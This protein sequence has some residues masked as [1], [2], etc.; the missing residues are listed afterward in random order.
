M[1]MASTAL[2]SPALAKED[3]W[4]I[5]A[6]FGPM[7]VEDLDL[8]V[9]AGTDE[10]VVGADTGYD[11]GGYVGYDFG[12]FR[13]EAEVSYRDA[14]I[15]DALIGTTGIASG[16]G[17]NGRTPSGSYVAD[18]GIDALSFM[19]NGLFDFGS[20]DGIQAYAG[21]GIG[22]ARTNVEMAVN[23]NGPSIDDSS[24]DLAWQLLAGVRA[25]L[26]DNIDVGL[27]YRMFTAEDVALVDLGGRDLDGKLRTHSLMGTLSY[28]FGA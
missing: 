21:A 18:G 6:E 2:A 20:D 9:D 12:A 5:G 25:P 26:T 8:D 4:Y 11:V 24:S 14:D 17:P 22:V 3:A 27:R 15:E 16:L 23:V 19:L 13:L 7:I 1:A 28:N 10:I